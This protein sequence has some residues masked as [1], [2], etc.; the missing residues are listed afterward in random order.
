[1]AVLFLGFLRKLHTVFSSGSTSL[2]SHK[3]CRR[4][5]F[6]PHSLQ[7]LLFVGF[8]VIT[9]LTGM[10]WYLIVLTCV[11]LIIRDVQ[12][13]FMCLLTSLEK[14]YLDFLF[15]DWA[16]WFLLL[17]LLSCTICLYILEIKPLSVASFANVS[18]WLVGCLFILLMISFAVWKLV[19]LIRSHLFIFA[20][21]SISLKETS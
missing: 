7:H 14:V 2:H 17:L 15:F 3:Q 5:L 4:V 10:R 13:L 21:I 18:F 20:F 16:V 19:S 11:S 12:H 6:S 8:L 1:M 9:I